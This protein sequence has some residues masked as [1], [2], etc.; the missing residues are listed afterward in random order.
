M[1]WLVI[2]GLAAAVIVAAFLAG[3]STRGGYTA[4]DV[5]KA[6]RAAGDSATA[7]ISQRYVDELIDPMIDTIRHYKAKAEA[8]AKIVIQRVPVRI[9]DTVPVG[10]QS[11]DSLSR[12]VFP[13]VDTNGVIVRETLEL[14][15]AVAPNTRLRRELGIEVLPDTILAALLKLPDG[16]SRF[17]ALA[18]AHGYTRVIDAAIR[19]PKGRSRFGLGC[20]GGLAALYS[21]GVVVAGPGLTCGVTVRF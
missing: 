20:A 17:A 9:V 6:K 12:F 2:F 11:T 4:A 15:P 7:A 21:G 10:F 13:A 18:G 16:T 1:K 8:G 3:A 14:R 19:P 5:A